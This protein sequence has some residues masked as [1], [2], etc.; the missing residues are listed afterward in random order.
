MKIGKIGNNFYVARKSVVP[1][2]GKSK[3]TYRAWFLVKSK[4]QYS[5]FVPMNAIS[6]PKEWVG[7][8]IRIRIEIIGDSYDE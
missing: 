6:F 4:S 3:K 5:G 2:H 1:D 8:K 7:K